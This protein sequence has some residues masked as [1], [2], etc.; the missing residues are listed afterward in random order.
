MRCPFD[1]LPLGAVRPGDE[2]RADF[3]K[4]GEVAFRFAE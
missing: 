3:G 2:V 1:D 4:L